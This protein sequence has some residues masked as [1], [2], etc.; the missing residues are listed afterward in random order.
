MLNPWL[1]HVCKKFVVLQSVMRPS[2]TGSHD[3]IHLVPILPLLN[4][5]S[6]SV[7]MNIN[8]VQILVFA[9]IVVYSVLYQVLIQ[10]S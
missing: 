4:R 6:S 9:Y 7:M 3:I 10:S 2:A 8:S 1:T 5:T